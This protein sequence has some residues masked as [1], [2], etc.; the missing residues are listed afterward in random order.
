MNKTAAV[1]GA[2]ISGMQAALSLAER[3]VKVYLIEKTSSIGGIMARLD[4]TMPTLDCSICI[5]SPFMLAVDRNPMIDI[6]TLT[7]IIGAEKSDIGYKLTLRKRP[8]YVDMDKCTGCRDCM[9]KCP[10]KIT[11]EHEESFGTVKAIHFD[12]DQAIPAVPYIDAEN[13]LML[14]KG[15]CGNC[16]KFCDKDAIDFEQKEE[17]VSLEVSSVI[18]ATGARPY[19]PLDRMEYGYGRYKNVI[20]AMELERLL[21][22]SGPT[23]GNV[24]RASDRKEPKNIAFINCV[25]SRDLKTGRGYCSKVC[26]MYGI[27]EALL[28]K[29]HDPDAN[30][31]I[32]YIDIRASGKGYEEFF[33]NAKD[34]IRFVRGRPGEILEHEDNDLLIRY[35]NT[36]TQEVIEERFDMVVLNTALVPCEE[37]QQL[38][39]MFGISVNNYGF[40]MPSKDISCPIDTEQDKVFVVGAC[41]GPNDITDCVSQSI[42]AVSKTFAMKGDIKQKEKR[43]LPGASGKDPRIGVFVCHCGKNIGKYVDVKDVVEYAKK[44]PD[45]VYAEDSL[46]TCSDQGQKSIRD[47]IKK[48]KLNRVVVAACSP[49]THENTFQEALI[50]AGLNPYMLEMANI[51]NQCSWVH[52]KQYDLATQKAKDLVRM[53]VAKARLLEPLYKR[54][55]DVVQHVAVI[56]GGFTGM[57]SALEMAK[58]GFRVS[59][60]EREPKLGGKASVTNK[61]KDGTIPMELA[62]MMADRIEEDDNISVFLSSEV[63]NVE[64]F[65]GDFILDVSTPNGIEKI[66]CGTVIIATGFDPADVK[67]SGYTTSKSVITDEK[68][69]SMVNC[70]MLDGKNYVFILC[71]GARNEQN[72]HCSRFCCISSLNHVR[73]LL[74]DKPDANVTILYR[75][76][77]AYG[78]HEDTYREVSEKG[79]NFIRYSP[80]MMPHIDVDKKVV[81][82]YD[83]TSSKTRTIKFDYCVLERGA[84]PSK[85]TTKLRKLFK[86]SVVSSGFFA[87]AHLK[88]A[89]LDTAL[90]GVFIAGSCQY[91]KGISEAITQAV[92]AAGRASI[93]MGGG[94]Y[95]AI[96]ITASVDEDKCI[97]C[98][99][100]MDM[101]PYK[102]LQMSEDGTHMEVIT[103][104][105][106]GCGTCAAFCPSNAITVSG[107]TYKQ[108]KEKLKAT[109]EGLME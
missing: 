80:E 107:F 88:L 54:E 51:R 15:T 82:V 83:T 101:C 12:F 3:G 68:F 4:K 2:G 73:C 13:C 93:V 31:T 23:E 8:R 22:A 52:S 49:K 62:E 86:M 70:G 66:E 94:T 24:I 28:V 25:G 58:N 60:I 100:C 17:I 95:G 11:L 84:I 75:D 30:V 21:S 18:L 96:P 108:E 97:A 26:C 41:Q 78:Y 74:E 48:E 43:P 63:E 35:E 27:K 36:E 45:V 39:D 59:L 16:A 89:P 77:R 40:F 72:P 42:G 32:F 65:V 92:S 57:A 44:L 56:G 47:M 91:P 106:K 61:Q 29:D 34:S 103:V 81:E 33:Q 104:S 14:I 85:G 71:V 7:D 10:K 19:I 38:S 69:S 46:F 37:A 99:L 50:E 53:S 64:G 109:F 67:S 90:D 76:I 79:A 5:L 87:E 102:A 20:T 55:V 105:C 9:S 1:V 98:K 6:L